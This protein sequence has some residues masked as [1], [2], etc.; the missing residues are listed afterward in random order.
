MRINIDADMVDMVVLIPAHIIKT[1]GSSIEMNSILENAEGKKGMRGLPVSP[2]VRTLDF[3][4]VLSCG[5]DVS[6]PFTAL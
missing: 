5:E 6:F 4:A 2:K 3:I 1:A